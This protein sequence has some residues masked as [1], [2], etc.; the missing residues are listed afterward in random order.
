MA[1]DFDPNLALIL[2]FGALALIVL[3]YDA[4]F[5]ISTR[6]RGQVQP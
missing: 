5:A 1:T 2:G 4:S 6:G 3:G